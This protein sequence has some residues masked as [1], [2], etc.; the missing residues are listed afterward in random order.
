M[1]E[2]LRWDEPESPREWLRAR[3]RAFDPDDKPERPKEALEQLMRT[4]R[5]PRSSAR[6]GEIAARISLKRCQDRAFCRFR[7]TLREWFPIET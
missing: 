4:L 5:R 7:D 6:Y 2:V 3:G 1:Q